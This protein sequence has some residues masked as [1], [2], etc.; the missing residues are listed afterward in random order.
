VKDSIHKETT[1]VIPSRMLIVISLCAA[2]FA[3]VAPAAQAATPQAISSGAYCSN[4]HGQDKK[5]I[6]PSFH[7]IAAKYAG[8]PK[9]A[10]ALAAK[11]RAGGKGVWGPV[12]MPPNGEKII[13]DADLG[14]VL[15]WILKQ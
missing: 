2:P 8:D 12:A 3:V 6:G 5:I 14:V 1:Q 7:D 13:S 4:C 10:T 9:A 15:A 11:V